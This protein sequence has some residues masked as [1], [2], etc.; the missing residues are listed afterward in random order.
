M[1]LSTLLVAVL[2]ASLTLVACGRHHQPTNDEIRDRAENRLED[3][4]DDLDASD[5]QRARLTAILDDA[6]PTV[7]AM[8]DSRKVYGKSI[9]TEL[10]QPKPD[11]GVVRNLIRDASADA[12]ANVKRLTDSAVAAH[13]VLTPEQRAELAAEWD[14]RSRDRRRPPAWI[15]DAI[16]KRGLDEIDATDAQ[17]EYVLAK[18]DLFE[19][20]ANQLRDDGQVA[21]QL[22][23]KQLTA[24]KVDRAAIDATIDAM[25]GKMTNLAQDVGAAAAEFAG[26]LSDEQRQKIAEEF[27]NRQ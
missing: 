8:R 21:K 4:M 6:M 5:A 26:T 18:K 9:V 15:L 12:T 27:M 23:R 14:A 10:M 13:A 19:P 20:R 11:A 17:F 2:V 24:S 25:S 1:R 22:F 7:Y 16:V 3:V